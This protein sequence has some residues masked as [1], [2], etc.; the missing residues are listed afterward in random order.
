MPRNAECNAWRFSSWNT[1]LATNN[2]TRHPGAAHGH[3]APRTASPRRGMRRW[4]SRRCSTAM[5][6]P[7]CM[8]CRGTQSATHADSPHGTYTMPRNNHPR[9]PG[10]AH[11]HQ[12]STN[13]LGCI[14]GKLGR[15]RISRGPHSPCAMV[16][17]MLKIM[18]LGMAIKTV[19]LC[20]LPSVCLCA[21]TH[22]SARTHDLRVVGVGRRVR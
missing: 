9:H 4:T 3:Q 2:H 20:L 5:T 17:R 14:L 13:S 11:G 1:S 12:A 21:C 16:A 22:E 8:P 10:A 7:P 15:I 6:T 18:E 19:N